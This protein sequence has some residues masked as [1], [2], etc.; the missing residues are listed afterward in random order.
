M[1]THV[2]RRQAL[3]DV[4]DGGRRHA[5]ELADLRGA[6]QHLNRVLVCESTNTK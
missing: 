4:E 6:L 1:L 3:L 2:G 5:V